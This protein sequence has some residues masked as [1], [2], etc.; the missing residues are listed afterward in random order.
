[1]KSVTRIYKETQI[2]ILSELMAKSNINDPNKNAIL[3]A[4]VDNLDTDTKQFIIDRIFSKSDYIPVTKNCYFKIHK[5]N[6]SIQQHRNT[7]YMEDIMNDIGLM[8]DDYVF[9]QVVSSKNWTDEFVT[10]YN[11]F[12]TELFYHDKK[13]KIKRFGLALS[14][15]DILVIEKNTIPHFKT[16]EDGSLHIQGIT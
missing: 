5:D 4:L 1:M 2:N 10:H 13:N 11:Q 7:E 3:N 9:G 12:S 16:I 8:E 14:I 15:N 6:A